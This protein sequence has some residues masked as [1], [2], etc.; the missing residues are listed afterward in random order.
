MFWWSSLMDIFYKI[1]K[2][3]E[4]KNEFES[5]VKRSYFKKKYNITVGL[6]S[7]GCFD[8]KRIPSNTEIGRYCS[9]SNTSVILNGNHGIEYVSLHPYLY[10]VDLCLVEK[11]TIK[12][13]KL[14]VSDDVWVGHNAIILPKVTSIGRGA[15][16][17]AGSVVTKD[18]GEYQIVA[19]NPAKLIR[20]RFGES[21]IARLNSS[22]WWLKDKSELKQLIDL[23]KMYDPNKI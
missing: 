13:T 14:K 10:N 15:I 2:I 20:M 9:F 5:L 4:S 16:I 23:G 12:R 3:F 21:T 22:Q 7:Y 18:V 6:Y 11:E 19:G 8:P 17:G 1:K